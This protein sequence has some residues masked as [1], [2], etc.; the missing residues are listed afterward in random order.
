MA[1]YC[2]Q[3]GHCA[4]C[5]KANG[6]GTIGN[7]DRV[8]C[9]TDLP[10]THVTP[11]SA[12]KKAIKEYLTLK[13]YF[14]FALMAGLGAYPGAPDII[15]I[16]HDRSYAIEVKAPGGRQSEK[17]KQFQSRWVQAGGTYILG[18]I[19]EVMKKL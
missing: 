13:G 2:D 16:K 5:E 1:F 6:H 11:E 17:Q 3:H 19:D 18:G 7:S 4:L 10:W 15:A 8:Y 14:H 12:E 9:F